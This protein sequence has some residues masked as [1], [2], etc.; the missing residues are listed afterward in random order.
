MSVS[1]KRINA[2]VNAV[3]GDTVLDFGAVQ[4]DIANTDKQTWLHQHLVNNFDTVIGVDRLKSEVKTLNERGYNFVTGDVTEVRIDRTVDTVVAGE[5]I[6]HVSNPGDMIASA[7]AHLDTGGRLII[8]TPNPWAFFTYRQAWKGKMTPNKE[9]SAWFGPTVLKQLIQRYG[10]RVLDVTIT[11][12]EVKG[13][14]WLL[15]KSGFQL[16]GG[17]HIVLTAEYT[18]EKL[19]ETD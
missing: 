17:R 18:G 2:I 4:H 3:K 10:F 1:Q 9:H 15:Y 13:P 5:I 16:V 7:A 12:P 19:R 6:E 14:S 11:P 8:T